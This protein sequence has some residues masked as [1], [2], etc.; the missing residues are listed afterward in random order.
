[1]TLRV[2]TYTARVM[3]GGCMLSLLLFGA[4]CGKKGPPVIPPEQP[5]QQSPTVTPP[6]RPPEPSPAV[7]PQNRP[8]QP[9]SGM[10]QNEPPQ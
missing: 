9:S 4:G 1:M 3:L 5:T 7:T 2:T 6:D 8:T 10:G